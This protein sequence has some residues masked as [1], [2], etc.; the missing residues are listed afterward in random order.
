LKRNRKWFALFALLVIA[1]LALTACGQGGDTGPGQS[2]EQGQQEQGQQAEYDENGYLVVN[3]GEEP[4][5][6]DPQLA[7]DTV[8]FDILGS[9]YE[10]LVRRDPETGGFKP[11]LGMALDWQVSEDGT[12]YTFKLRQDNKWSD[13]QPVTAHDFEYAWKR[14]VDPRTASKYAFILTDYIKGGKAVQEAEGDA[15]IEKALENFGVKAVDDYT[16]EVTLE[17]PTPWFISLLEF[18]TYRPVR[19]DIVEKYGDKFATE[20]DT[21]VYSGPFMITEWEHGNRLK[22]EKNPYYWDADNV[23][24][25]YIEFKMIKENDTIVNLYETG[26]LDAIGVPSTHVEIFEQNHKDEMG[27]WLDGGTFYLMMN[28]QKKPFNN[29][30]ARKAVLL[31]IDRKT[32]VDSLRKGAGVPAQG[33][34]NPVITAPDQSGSFYEKYVAPLNLYPAEGDKQQAKQ[35][36]DQ[37][38]QEEGISGTVK[39]EL[40]CYDTDTALLDCQYFQQQL[41]DALGLE[42]TIKQV[43][44]D[45]KLEIEKQGNF[46]ISYAGW[47][48][49]YD[50]PLTFLDLWE[51]KGS[52]NDVK[53]SN[54]EYD[55]LVQQLRSELDPKKQIDIA[56]ELEKLI[57]EEAPVATIYHRESR[58]AQKPYVKN[59]I[60]RA[61]GPEHDW[62]WAYTQ[63]RPQ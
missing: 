44:F 58:Y 34:T 35:L 6:L 62:K 19:K 12:K 38:L 56:L 61:L 45:Q 60:R 1:S 30:K 20:A 43:P 3:L 25:A 2:G 33:F 49:D 36:W 37:A 7:T 10:G 17:K 13:G 55:R 29:P 41:K 47:G 28:N 59:I 40:L 16:L 46:T 4:P 50:H 52:H 48:P 23:K 32:Y 27:T 11:G 26:Q 63:G 18:G 57:A 14:A 39:A 5:S 15:A 8:S 53:Y 54:P 42:V 51:T 24:L 31:A 22:L 9:T 21:A